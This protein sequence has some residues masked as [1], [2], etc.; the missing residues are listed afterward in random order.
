MKLIPLDEPEK[1][2]DMSSR[3]SYDYMRSKFI[4]NGD[5]FIYSNKQDEVKDEWIN[6]ILNDLS[7]DLEDLDRRE[8]IIKNPTFDPIDEPMENLISDM[9]E[10]GDCSLENLLDVN[11]NLP[12][13]F[14]SIPPLKI[15]VQPKDGYHSIKK[16]PRQSNM[17][18]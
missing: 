1:K 12:F 14:P 10:L 6:K 11:I 9:M 8:V 13:E 4:E 15:K 2:N 18:E 16:K 5:P 17:E 7:M 3:M